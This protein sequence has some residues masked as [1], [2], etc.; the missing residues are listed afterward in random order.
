MLTKGRRAVGVELGNGEKLECDDVVINADFGHAVSTLFAPEQLQRYSPETL[1]KKNWSCS[2]FMMYLGLDRSYP[3]ADHHTIVFAKDYKRNLEDITHRG[4][5][6]E[7]ISIYVRNSSI[8]DPTTRSR[9]SLR[10]LYSCA[11]SQ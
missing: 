7:D 10:S 2:T 8:T 11:G 4:K 6:S 1:R 5:T 3:E 9:G